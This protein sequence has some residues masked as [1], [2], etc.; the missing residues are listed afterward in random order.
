MGFTLEGLR[1]AHEILFFSFVVLFHGKYRIVMVL[2]QE[3]QCSIGLGH[4]DSPN[5]PRV[6]TSMP[7]SRIGTITEKLS[8][9]TCARLVTSNA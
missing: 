9:R 1:A 3:T 5:N 4:T 7:T 6:S 8:S 2:D